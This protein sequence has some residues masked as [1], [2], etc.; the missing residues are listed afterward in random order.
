MICSPLHRAASAGQMDIVRILVKH[1]ADTTVADRVYEA[2]PAQWAE[3]NGQA[4]TAEF[5]RSV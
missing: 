4:E 5:L 1:G 2:T 3:Y